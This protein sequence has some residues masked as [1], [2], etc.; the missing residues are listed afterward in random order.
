MWWVPTPEMRAWLSIEFD[1]A[2]LTSVSCE[3]GTPDVAREPDSRSGTGA[4]LEPVSR[5]VWMFD[6]SQRADASGAGVS[7]MLYT[8]AVCQRPELRYISLRSSAA[9]STP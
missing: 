6:P 3:E 8:H 2:L 1:F 4:R 7:R 5:R 9:E